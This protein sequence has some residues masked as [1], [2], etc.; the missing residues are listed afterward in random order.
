M[1][2]TL[3]FLSHTHEKRGGCKTVDTFFFERHN[4][5]YTVNVHNPGGWLISLSEFDP[6]GL[7]T[8]GKSRGVFM[9]SGSKQEKVCVRRNMADF[10]WDS[11][12]TERMKR[13]ISLVILS[14]LALF[15]ILNSDW[16]C[17]KLNWSGRKTNKSFSFLYFWSTKF[18]PQ[19]AEVSRGV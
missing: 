2:C 9:C 1:W 3:A 10:F 16:F 13:L 12:F 5:I 17:F 6:F 4:L 18:N 15:C 7:I 14:S 8:F 11:W 19:W